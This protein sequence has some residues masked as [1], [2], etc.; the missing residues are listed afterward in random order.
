M[1]LYV[2]VFLGM[3]GAGLLGYGLGFKRASSFKDLNNEAILYKMR[4]SFH[5]CLDDKQSDVYGC[6]EATFHVGKEKMGIK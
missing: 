1:N 6:Y 2:K 5:I 3:M 4:K